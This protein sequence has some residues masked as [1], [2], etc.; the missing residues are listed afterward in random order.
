MLAKQ[1]NFKLTALVVLGSLIWAVSSAS[2]QQPQPPSQRYQPVRSAPPNVHVPAPGA[3]QLSQAGAN[4]DLRTTQTNAAGTSFNFSDAPQSNATQPQQNSGVRQVAY[5]QPLGQPAQQPRAAEIDPRV[6][7]KLRGNSTS[8]AD[9]FRP[10][11]PA[12]RQ[13]Q[14]QQLTPPQTSRSFNNSQ[15]R[16]DAQSFNSHHLALQGTQA[17]PVHN[18]TQATPIQLA[19]KPTA[20]ESPGQAQNGQVQQVAFTTQEEMA[21]E[22]QNDSLST[23]R[24]LSSLRSNRAQ[25]AVAQMA[26]DEDNNVRQTAATMPEAP[27]TSI[28]LSTPA[29]VVNTYGPTTVGI[30]KTAIYK[31]TCKNDSDR[32]VER[33][34]IGIDMPQWV[35][36]QNINAT[37]GQHEITD[38]NQQARLKWIVD[39]IPANT[40]HTV[41]IN[42]VPRKAETFDLGVDWAFAPR[43]GSAHVTVTEPKLEM[44]ISGPNDVLYGEKA[45]YHVTVSNPGTG[46]AEKVSVMLP[47]ALGG[48]RASLGNIA[49]GS[50]K[51]FQVELFARKSGNIDLAATAVA[52]GQLEAAVDRKI[53]V[54]RANLNVAV[55]GPPM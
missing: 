48:E 44:K 36:L 47:E 7:L 3:R 17:P 38:G 4:G 5:Q 26:T 23:L 16:V 53:L 52:D 10:A 46:A 21:S 15:P 30:H 9:Y 51:N 40:T 11:N 8:P 6:P 14:S 32:D 1:S 45:I 22:T 54:R 35:D 39:R 29:M 24:G 31:V 42:A 19:A 49:A 25:H 50:E 37:G 13:S 2:A 18:R 27:G 41:T 20:N 12:S 33:V 43:T 28:Q 34:L 55:Q